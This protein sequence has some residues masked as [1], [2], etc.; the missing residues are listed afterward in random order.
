MALCLRD[1]DIKAI[2]SRSVSVESGMMDYLFKN[3]EDLYTYKKHSPFNTYFPHIWARYSNLFLGIP[4]GQCNWQK[5]VGVDSQNPATSQ[6]ESHRLKNG[7]SL[8]GSHHSRAVLFKRFSRFVPCL[9]AFYS[10]ANSTPTAV[11]LFQ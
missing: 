6:E 8:Q 11:G 1:S 7:V 5:P 10:S 2:L 3:I 4:V 9:T